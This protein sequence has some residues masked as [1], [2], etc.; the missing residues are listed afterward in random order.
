MADPED[1]AE[2]SLTKFVECTPARGTLKADKAD[3]ASAPGSESDTAGDFLTDDLGAGS[4]CHIPTGTTPRGWT[5][6]RAG[7]RTAPFRK[8][9]SER[10]TRAPEEAPN[11]NIPCFYDGPRSSSV[12]WGQLGA[13]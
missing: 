11:S 13:K 10:R 5:W 8:P 3:A 7:F 2:T 4:L 9:D 1:E 12:D 6:V